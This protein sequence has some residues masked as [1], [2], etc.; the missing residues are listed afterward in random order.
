M[1]RK[2]RILLSCEHAG[3]RVPRAYRRLFAADPDVLTTH[4]GYDIGIAPVAAALQEV[5]ECPLCVHEWTRLLAD[6]NRTHQPSLFSQYSKPLNETEKQQLIDAYYTPYQER[7]GRAV[8]ELMRAGPVL[9]LSLHSFTPQLRGR[10]RN[11][12]IGI[13]YDPARSQETAYANELQRR[14]QEWSGLRIRRN[15]PY[16]GRSDGMTRRFRRQY[17][18]SRYL[19]FEIEFNQALLTSLTPKQRRELVGQLAKSL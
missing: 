1:K 17:P 19:G 18:Q 14:L 12:D 4:R 2:R 8:A 9:H 15:Y 3:N 13:L 7:L 11:A 6:V 5:L 10:K 16:R